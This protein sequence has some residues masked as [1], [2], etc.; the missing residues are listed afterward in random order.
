MRLFLSTLT[1]LF[2]Q[3]PINVYASIETDSVPSASRT[4]S[5]AFRDYREEYRDE[6]REAER[7]GRE[8]GI[9]EGREIGIKEVTIEAARRMI[10]QGKLNDPEIADV[11]GLTIDKIIELRTSKS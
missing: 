2:I 4:S 7:R 5:L 9:K 11:T 3:A 6:F 8:I 10:V 1:I